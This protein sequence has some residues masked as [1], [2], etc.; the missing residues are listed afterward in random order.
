MRS[1]RP[2]VRLSYANVTATLALFVAL[3]GTGYAVTKVRG[4]DIAPRTITAKNVKKGTLTGTEIARGAITAGKLSRGV[5][6]MLPDDGFGDDGGLGPFDGRDG[7]PGEPGPPGDPGPV[8]SGCTADRG[9]L[10][11]DTDL[12][13]GGTA[14]V[15][16]GGNVA[17]TVTAYRTTC[18]SRQG[19]D[20]VVL[21]GGDGPSTTAAGWFANPSSRTFDIRSPDRVLRVNNSQPAALGY[22][23]DRYELTLNAD[24]VVQ[25]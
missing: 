25:P 6:G 19:P 10:C 3:G 2:R 9:L 11:S 14:D 22:E 24:S 7:E 12:A 20:C 1:W 8:G 16:V 13:D 5:R 17:F 23:R 15:V 18:A 21:L 4:K